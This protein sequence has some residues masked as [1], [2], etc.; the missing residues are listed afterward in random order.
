M[1][2]S[3]PPG[4]AVP[5]PQP[6]ISS[7]LEPSSAPAPAAEP[8]PEAAPVAAAP[9]PFA[10]VPLAPAAAAPAR[11]RRW[12]WWSCLL[13]A[14]LAVALA[15]GLGAG[16]YALFFNS[17]RGQEA[18]AF[19]AGEAALA[20]QDWAAA[21]AGYSQALAVSPPEWR[22]HVL[23]ATLGRAIARYHRAD[24]PGAL[25]DFDAVQAADAAR[26]EPYVYRT[27]IYAEQGD[28]EAA[29]R[30]GAEAQQHDAQFGLPYAL[31]AE[32][33]YLAN[34]YPAA[35]SAAGAAIARDDTLALAYR[36][37][38][39]VRAWAYD[40]EA[41]AADLDRALSLQ[42]AD[43]EG[44]AV[45]AWIALEQGDW[46]AAE[47]AAEQAQAAAPES[48]AA[49]W[50]QAM[51]ELERYAYS[52][53]RTHIDAAIDLDAARAEFYVTRAQ[54]YHLTADDGRVLEDLEQALE[55][56]PNYLPAL[57][58]MGWWHVQQ[59]DTNDSAADGQR[60][61]DL[62]A[63]YA[64]GYLLQAEYHR[65]RYD[66]EKQLAAAQQ[67]IDANPGLARPYIARGYYYF[68]QEALDKARQDFEHALEL[69]PR[70]VSALVGLARVAHAGDDD[71]AALDYLDQALELGPAVHR[72][73]L[74]RASVLYAGERTND[75]WSALNE[76]LRLD[77]DDPDSLGLRGEFYLWE[78]DYQKALAD[79]DRVIDAYPT[80]APPYADRAEAFRLDG[81]ATRAAEDARQAIKL[82][83]R[84]PGPYYTLAMLAW[85]EQDWE[86]VGRHATKLMTFDPDGYDGHALR[87]ASYFWRGYFQQAVIDL[88]RATKLDA[89]GLEAW[90]Y[91]GR[92]YAELGKVEAA[93]DAYEHA[94]EL[95]ESLDDLERIDGELAFLRTVPP[96]VKGQ[97]TIRNEAR[98]YTL[99][100]GA[101]WRQAPTTGQPPETVVLLVGAPG[102]AR[103]A[104]L[105]VA[106][107]DQLPGVSAREFL[108]LYDG[109]IKREIP[110]YQSGPIETVMV[111]GVRGA[112]MDYSFK[113]A[114]G[115]EQVTIQGRLYVVAGGG[116]RIAVLDFAALNLNYNYV[117]D[118][119][120]VVVQ[121]FAFLPAR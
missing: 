52:G 93:I 10:P 66:G 22:Q 69:H 16:G 83:A 92:S 107:L 118:D 33:A 19:A 113:Q 44:Q 106:L 35:L 65:R 21:E 39:S 60:L 5:S 72:L 96:L 55:L 95:T 13:A 9:E 82:D 49:L 45:R 50:A 1:N 76:A 14:V 32:Q 2:D 6:P 43:A 34:D 24:Y 67:A 91:L 46:A 48:A 75:A 17:R 114:V 100:Y 74:E 115:G 111:G 120:E 58:G 7:A 108:R 94:R 15:A 101:T 38:G 40:L 63:G 89:E 28:R 27:R 62:N 42:P 29:L 99:S 102:S 61:L 85:D 77:P 54:S 104:N 25:A 116:G 53:A 8:A 47:A 90:D 64:D 3:L 79:L 20:A 78:G 4:A 68:D 57:A 11:R 36:V 37:R 103:L 98:G 87:G 26:P 71:G 30:A 86:A 97:R 23:A 31:Q 81:R 41:A 80:F 84:L 59:H 112:Q 109:V 12:R 73:Y 88:T 18:R 51:L 110:T 119:A 105:T 70:S 121:T 56:R 117:V